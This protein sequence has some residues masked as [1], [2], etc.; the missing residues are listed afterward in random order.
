M[1]LRFDP[2]FL[3]SLV[4]FF[5]VYLLFVGL[6]SPVSD[7]CGYSVLPASQ[8]SSKHLF[9]FLDSFFHFLISV[10]TFENFY[11]G[12]YIQPITSPQFDQLT[13]S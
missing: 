7:Q 8:P 5:S 11:S 4:P 13:Q 2:G 3:F 12:L 6:L 9:V 10:F 1:L